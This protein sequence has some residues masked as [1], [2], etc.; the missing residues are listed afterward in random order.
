MEQPYNDLL[1]LSSTSWIETNHGIDYNSVIDITVVQQSCIFGS[2][3]IPSKNLGDEMVITREA[4]K[5]Q[6]GNFDRQE[7]Y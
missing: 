2:K 6:L 7:V 3:R 4:N 5:E 1:S